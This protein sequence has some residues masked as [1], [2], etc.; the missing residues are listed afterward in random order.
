MREV[1][2]L[3]F[4]DERA[5]PAFADVQHGIVCDVVHEPNAPRAENAAVGNVY[6]V[7][8]EILDRVESLGFAVSSF[9]PSFLERVVL[10]FAF[11]GLITDGAIERMVDEEHLEHTF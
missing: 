8:A 5:I 2:S 10:E 9:T 7:A 3:E 1:L 6:H 11:P 4:S